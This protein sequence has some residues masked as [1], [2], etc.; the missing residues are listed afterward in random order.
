[1]DVLSDDDG[2]NDEDDH[3]DI[4]LLESHYSLILKTEA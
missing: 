2:D 1:M 4:S 3:D